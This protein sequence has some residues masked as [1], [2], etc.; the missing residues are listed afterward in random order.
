MKKATMLVFLLFM[1]NYANAKITPQKNASNEGLLKIV[2]QEVNKQITESNN[3]NKKKLFCTVTCTIYSRDSDGNIIARTATAGSIFRNCQTAG[4]K[5]CEKARQS[6][7]A[8]FEEED[9]E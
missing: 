7:A 8:S 6:I 4:E 1:I 3:N 9:F 5:A 2:K